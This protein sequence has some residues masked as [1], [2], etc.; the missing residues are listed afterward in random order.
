MMSKRAV[1]TGA[2]GFIGRHVMRALHAAGYDVVAITIEGRKQE[3]LREITFP[4]EHVRVDDVNK[5]GNAVRVCEAPFVVHL[6]GC[7]TTERSMRSLQDTLTW[8]L[9]STVDVLTACVDTHVERVILMGSCEEYG[10]NV[11]PFDPRLA[12]DPS[13]PYGASKAAA[14]AYARMFYNSYKLNTVI[15][16]PSVVYGPGQSPRMLISQVLRA[17][18]DGEPVAVTEGI[19]T[20][21]FIFV[22]DVAD[23]IVLSLENEAMDGRSWNVGSGEVVTVRE[24]LQRIERITDKFGLIQYGARPYNDREIFAY[25]PEVEETHLVLNWKPRVMLEEGLRLT[26]E[27]MRGCLEVGS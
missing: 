23:A 26:W 15:L 19:Q 10:Q 24:C 8:N 18:A 20:R 14:S 27:S 2:S 12:A 13:S 4:F 9:L 5:L 21:D 7:V 1:V 6:N 3:A 11:S 16:R 22:S 17:L 25:R